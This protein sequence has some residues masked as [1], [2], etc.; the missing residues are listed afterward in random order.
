MKNF[1][2]LLL[3]VLGTVHPNSAQTADPRALTNAGLA[4]YRAGHFEQA[5]MLLHKAL[6]SAQRTGDDYAAATAQTYLGDVY[7]S[8]DR[9]IESEQAF[10][11]A[12][13]IL[14]RIP[15]NSFETAIVLRNLGT[16][17]SLNQHHSE[18]L[19][20]LQEALKLIQQN[21]P[22]ELA[23]ARQILNSLAMVYFR[24][25]KTNRAE[26]L[27]LQAITLV[28]NEPYL[29]HAGILNN[30]GMVY[31]RRHRL[32]RAEEAFKQS[33]K[34]T[35]QQMGALHTDVALPLNNLGALYTELR[36]YAEAEELY[37]R[38]LTILEQT[39]P[40]QDAKIVRTLHALSKT[41]LRQGDKTRAES[42]LA[43]AVEI[44]RRSPVCRGDMPTILAAY[45]DVLKS[46]GQP[47][48]AQRLRLEARQT[49]AELGLTVRVPS[50]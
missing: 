24:Q 48:L 20:V 23:L 12:L 8:E 38:S 6:E 41:Y 2:V 18:A 49:K 36:R 43:Q 9:L 13:S 31:Q 39:T 22:E 28:K 19:K 47:D 42:A 37:R 25:G 44:G 45:A 16:V 30:L 32:D 26:T 10:A 50:R 4:E 11:K 29:R 35:E 5:E 17:Y 27:L 7:Q 21:T 1:T 34:V 15:G 14:R 3:C 33:L 46:R 40:P